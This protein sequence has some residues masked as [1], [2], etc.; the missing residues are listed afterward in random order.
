MWSQRAVVFKSSQLLQPGLG[1]GD[2][3]FVDAQ[4]MEARGERLAAE[5][6]ELE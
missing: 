4:R 2:M 1:P 5:H 6:E 3:I